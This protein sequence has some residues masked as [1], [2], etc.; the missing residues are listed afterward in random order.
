[1]LLAELSHYLWDVL[2]IVNYKFRRLLVR[3]ADLDV[4]YQKRL[5]F[6]NILLDFLLGTART[7]LCGE[8]GLI[9]TGTHSGFSVPRARAWTIFIGP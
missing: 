1:M 6:T 4:G 7:F 5:D 3:L 2:S 8:S 9:I